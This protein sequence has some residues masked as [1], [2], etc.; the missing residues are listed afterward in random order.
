[1]CKKHG[2]ESSDWLYEHTPAVVVENDEVEF[3]D[4]TIQTDM[5]VTQN[6]PDIILVEKAIRKWTIIDI[7]V[8]S[9]FNAVTTEDWKVKKYQDIAFEVKRVHHVE[10]A[11]LPV[12]IEAI[13]TVPKRLIRSIE[14]LDIVGII[15]STQMTAL[16][17][18]AGILCRAMNI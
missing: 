1:M 8:R 17:G 3:W 5:T 6:R 4:L 7:A 15:A 10:T 16:L 12:V 18:T 9:D 11:I 2:L 13:G 14:L